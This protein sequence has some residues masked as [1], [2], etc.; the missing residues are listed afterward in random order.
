MNSNSPIPGFDKSNK[1][2]TP[3]KNADFT[4]IQPEPGSSF[5]ARAGDFGSRMVPILTAAF[6]VAAMGLSM[7]Y[8]L[9]NSSLQKADPE[10]LA[11]TSVQDSCYI[12]QRVAFYLPT[13][14]MLATKAI[15]DAH[16]AARANVC[17]TVLKAMATNTSF[18]EQVHFDELKGV[19][20]DLGGSKEDAEGFFATIPVAS[21]KS[22]TTFSA[23]IT[24]APGSA[25]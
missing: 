25:R 19:V 5:L 8:M 21:K 11:R 18:R 20:K 9:K 3:L 4:S 17:H 1:P 2:L 6:A 15:L 7:A 22:S 16:P 14:T 12:P 24:G 10:R 23:D 13:T